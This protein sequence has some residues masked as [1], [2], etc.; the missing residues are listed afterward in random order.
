MSEATRRVT[1]VDEELSERHSAF[2]CRKC[3]GVEIR[4]N[5]DGSHLCRVCRHELEAFEAVPFEVLQ[6]MEQPGVV[7]IMLLDAISIGGLFL[8]D[9]RI[10]H[11]LTPQGVARSDHRFLALFLD[12]QAAARSRFIHVHCKGQP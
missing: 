5:N 2:G 10:N 12:W 3:Y 11:S 1:A 8:S 6:M 7:R 4:E 9:M